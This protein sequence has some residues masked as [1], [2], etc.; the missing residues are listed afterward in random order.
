MKEQEEE[1]NIRLTR[2]EPIFRVHGGSV[3]SVIIPN[4]ERKPWELGAS[5]DGHVRD[6]KGQD[7]QG[8]EVQEQPTCS[9][10]SGGH[11]L[12]YGPARAALR[13]WGEP[14][15]LVAVDGELFTVADLDGNQLTWR[16][17]APTPLARL[18]RY[19]DRP[20]VFLH[21]ADVLRIGES[22]VHVCTNLD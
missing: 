1:Q 9:L 3:G 17:H 6:Q 14:Y 8:A 20:L 21:G 18:L 22:L 12:H 7:G 4:R 11:Y 10:L 19:K 16:H 13:E 5:D 15:R 2:G